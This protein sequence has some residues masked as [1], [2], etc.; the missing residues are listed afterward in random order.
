MQN[1][2]VKEEPKALVEIPDDEIYGAGDDISGA[3]IKIGRIAI[4]QSSS[5]LVKMDRA[6]QGA[7]MNVDAVK[8]LGYKETSPVQ[9]IPIKSFKYWIVSNDDTDE[10]IERFP[11][12]SQDELLREEKVGPIN[13]RRVFHHA[14]YV[15]LPSEIDGFDEMPYEIAFRST[16]LQEAK[17]FSSLLFKLR[18]RKEA[19]W[20][21]VFT[22]SCKLKTKDKYSWFAAEVNVGN[23]STL[24]QREVCKTWYKQ[25]GAVKSFNNSP[26]PADDNA[27]HEGDAY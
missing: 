17:K 1:Q 10:F 8:E 16:D 25:L 24:A 18:K 12:V 20:N 3:D 6:R 11:G 5:D 26:P 9:F 15:L 21:K 7:I 14:F 27:P 19:S 2:L 13:L 23:D 22:L 4:Q